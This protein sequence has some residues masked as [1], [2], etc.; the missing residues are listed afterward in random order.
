LTSASTAHLFVSEP[1]SDIGLSSLPKLREHQ[2][3][4][5]VKDNIR[6][7]NPKDIRVLVIVN[8]WNAHKN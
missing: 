2:S 4:S 5:V 8:M 1:L 6:Y 7:H 3:Q